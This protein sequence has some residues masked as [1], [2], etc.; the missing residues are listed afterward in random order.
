LLEVG[1]SAKASG[2]L[3]FQLRLGLLVAAQ[4][5][6]HPGHLGGP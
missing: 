3:T 1:Q 6:A 5:S 4:G 2:G